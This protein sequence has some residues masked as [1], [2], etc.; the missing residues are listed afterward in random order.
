VNRQEEI[1]H[2]RNRIKQIREIKQKLTN[3][4]MKKVCRMALEEAKAA[5]RELG[6]SDS[7]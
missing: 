3:P 2:W 4:D 6:A 1:A 5:L 7:D